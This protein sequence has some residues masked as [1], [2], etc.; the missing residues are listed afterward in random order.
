MRI[1]LVGYGAWGRM[2]AGTI[3]R[4][5]DL[6]LAVVMCVSDATARAT[7]ADFPGVAVYRDRRALWHPSVWKHIGTRT[8]SS[9][10]PWVA[11]S[12]PPVN[13]KGKYTDPWSPLVLSACPNAFV[14]QF[15]L[16]ALDPIKVLSEAVGLSSFHESLVLFI[17]G[18][19]FQAATAGGCFD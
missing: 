6:S 15:T 3:A 9:G 16:I 7:T 12:L 2:H 4:I 19:E 18:R 5:P 10:K 14:N 1:G 8:A 17:Q 11:H 13:I